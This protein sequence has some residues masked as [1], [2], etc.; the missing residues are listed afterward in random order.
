MIDSK[1]DELTENNYSM[2]ED[3]LFSVD[4][5]SGVPLNGTGWFVIGQKL[6][7]QERVE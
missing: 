2:Y 7:P 3:L 5:F 1:I 6:I 4:D